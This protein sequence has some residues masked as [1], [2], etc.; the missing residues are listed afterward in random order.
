MGVYSGRLVDM[1][2]A[3]QYGSSVAINYLHY[4]RNF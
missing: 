1:R 2:E 3:F 4:L